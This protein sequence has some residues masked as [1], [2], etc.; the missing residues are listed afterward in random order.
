MIPSH[1]PPSRAPESDYE[2]AKRYKREYDLAKTYVQGAKTELA[3]KEEE[4]KRKDTQLVELK[5]ELTE[6][7]RLISSLQD[8]NYRKDMTI[9]K[10]QEVPCGERKGLQQH[11]ILEL[12]KRLEVK[13]MEA[14]EFKESFRKA[15]DEIQSKGRWLM[16]IY[17]LLTPEQ[18]K[19][20]EGTIME[21]EKEQ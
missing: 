21:K 20:L 10:L 13:E 19:T 8:S 15:K 2:R 4:M 18:F 5:M 7:R 3:E 17:P 1:Q 16:K 11:R 9:E 6:N 12:K 14:E